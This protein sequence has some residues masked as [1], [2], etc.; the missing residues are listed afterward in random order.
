MLLVCFGVQTFKLDDCDTLDQAATDGGDMSAAVCG[1]RKKIR[2][3][4]HGC[5]VTGDRRDCVG[6]GFLMTGSDGTHPGG[7]QNK[8][9]DSG[10]D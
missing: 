8:E 4:K 6:E 10:G 5:S 9:T 2:N 3:E 1:G 7:S